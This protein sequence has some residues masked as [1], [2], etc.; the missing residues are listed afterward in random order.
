MTGNSKRRLPAA[1]VV[2]AVAAMAVAARHHGPL[3][4]GPG[5]GV[6]QGARPAIG[7][8]ALVLLIVIGTNFAKRRDDGFGLLHRAGTATAVL[9]TAAAVL[10]PIGLL[11]LGRRP[12]PPPA[13]LVYPD[14]PPTS[15]TP[16]PTRPAH[17][18]LPPVQRTG[19]SYSDW[20]V[21]GVLVLIAV[22]VL[23]LLVYLLFRLLARR[24]FPR[25]DTLLVDF[26][27]LAAELEDLEEA[28]AAGTEALEYEGDAREA[29]IACYSAMEQAVGAGGG[30]RRLTD[31]PEEFLRRV[32]A[33]KLIPEAP[34]SRLTELF[35][36]ARF[37]RHPIAESQRDEA[38][39]A[40]RE[41]SEHVR[42]R[43]AE[44][45]AATARAGAEAGAGA[46]TPEAARAGAT[47]RV[48]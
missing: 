17:R 45:A 22:A 28:V 19:K 36:E 47:G 21:E 14:P 44:L 26:D 34:A 3:L 12:Q 39:E 30:G 27:P 33:S 43:A 8:G 2:V 18:L 42:A 24:W 32:T 29:V 4:P 40:L 9:L 7:L 16:S 13:P 11:F 31:T 10:T 25:G 37:S 41:I 35:R 1:V 48:R 23:A 46:R 5:D 20:A 6:W 38:R 15:T